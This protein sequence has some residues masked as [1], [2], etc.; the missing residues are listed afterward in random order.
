MNIRFF[1]TCLIPA[2]EVEDTSVA[3]IGINPLET[4]PVIV[5]AVKEGYFLYRWSRSFT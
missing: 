5:L 2:D 1:L 4:I 3:V